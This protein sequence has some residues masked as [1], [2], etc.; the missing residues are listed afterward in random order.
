MVNF[1]LFSLASI[2]MTLILVRGAL[3]EPFR[4]N[5]AIKVEK[6]HRKQQKKGLPP[7]LTLVEFF[8]DLV[9]CVQCTGFWCGMFCGL[10]L[11]TTD[12]YW[13]AGSFWNL[14]YLANRLIMWLCCGFAGSFLASVGDILIEWMFFAKLRHERLIMAEDQQRAALAEAKQT[15]KVGTIAE[16]ETTDL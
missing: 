16:V 6:L 3:F 5:L 14:P 4:Q 11:L 10:F 12:S 2:G 8:H 15:E 9:H 13:S 1:L 7:E